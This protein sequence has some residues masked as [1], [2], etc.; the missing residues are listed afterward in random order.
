MDCKGE[1]RKKDSENDG[2]LSCIL[3]TEVDDGLAVWKGT[4]LVKEPLGDVLST[5]FTVAPLDVWLWACEYAPSPRLVE[6][7]RLENWNLECGGEI[8]SRRCKRTCSRKS[9][10]CGK[11]STVCSTKQSYSLDNRRALRVLCRNVTSRNAIL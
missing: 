11:Y 3:R 2:E 6:D 5:T 9:E 7:V 10:A 1:W 8:A 4:L